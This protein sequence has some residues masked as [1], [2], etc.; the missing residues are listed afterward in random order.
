MSAAAVAEKLTGR[1][2]NPR[3]RNFLVNCPAHDDREPSLSLCDGDDGKLLVYCFAGCSGRD[4]LDAIH[5]KIGTVLISPE[6]PSSSA[7][8]GSSEYQ[9]QQHDKA[10]WW[11]SQRRPITGS[12]AEKYLRE[13]RRIACP[14]PPTLGFLPSKSASI[15]RP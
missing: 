9:R 13:R 1:P 4:V 7:A 5:S 6:A 12:I 3:G 8:K 2:A 10:A 15:I 14:L 11:W